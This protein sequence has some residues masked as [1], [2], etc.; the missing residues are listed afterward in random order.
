MWPFARRMIL[1]LIAAGVTAAVLTLPGHVSI[2]LYATEID[3]PL[4]LVL[5]GLVALALIRRMGVRAARF[6][7]DASGRKR[8]R[9]DRALVRAHVAQ[10]A[11]RSDDGLK[12]AARALTLSDDQSVAALVVQAD[13]ALAAGRDEQAA[14]AY[15]M[16]IDRRET[17]FIGLKGRLHLALKA[18]D[19]SAAKGFAEQAHEV[20]P[21]SVDCADALI[22]LC[23]AQGDFEPALRAV[24]RALRAGAYDRQTAKRR[25]ALLSYAQARGL[26]AQGTLGPEARVHRRDLEIGRA[27]V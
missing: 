7:F 13:A 9:L 5:V 23:A 6:I 21:G 18:H 16:M 1:V 25:R 3:L 2:S 19:L 10:A 8:I 15:D 27:H 22:G 20:E 12:A 24:D 4:P 26:T 17:T 11:G 14:A